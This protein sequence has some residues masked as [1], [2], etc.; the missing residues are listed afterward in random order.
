LASSNAQSGSK[1]SGGFAPLAQ[2]RETICAQEPDT[3]SHVFHCI[4]VLEDSTMGRGILL[5]LLGV[6]IPIIILLWLFFGR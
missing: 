6:L 4:N 5:W 2:P 3:L 1:T